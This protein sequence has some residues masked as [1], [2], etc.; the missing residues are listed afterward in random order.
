M[1]TP[2]LAQQATEAGG[3]LVGTFRSMGV[4]GPRLSSQIILFL[5]VAF[6]LKRYAYEPILKLLDERRTTIKDGLENAAKIKEELSAAQASRA[7][8]LHKANEAASQ[9]LED[10]KKGV[11]V[12]AQ[13]RLQE[14][15]REAE[16]IVLTARQAAARER[17]KLIAEV[18]NDLLRLVVDATRRATGKV[19]TPEDQERI[20]GE[21]LAETSR[22]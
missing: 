20:K 13:Q 8:I 10:A 21:T 11:E 6:V 22:N 12:Q 19:L 14:A 5:V 7:A 4:D 18:R 1:L 16:Q 15:V 9:I 17:E 2:F 3:G